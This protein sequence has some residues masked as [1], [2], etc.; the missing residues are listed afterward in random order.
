MNSAPK[1]KMKL[2]DR[3]ANQYPNKACYVITE[4]GPAGE[5]LKPKKFRG[6]FRNAIE[7]LIRD[8]LNPAI[9]S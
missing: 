7:A 8:Q 6:R 2:G 5:I 4:V 3:K 1:L 9:P